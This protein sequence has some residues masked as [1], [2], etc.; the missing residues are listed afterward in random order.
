MN[1]NNKLMINGIN[2]KLDFRRYCATKCLIYIAICKLCNDPNSLSNFYFGQTRNSLMSRNNGHRDKFSIMKYDK[3]A[4]SMHIYDKHLEHFENKLLNYDF[5]VV[6]HVN[7][8]ALDRAEDFY[9][10]VTEA[11]LKGLNRYKLSK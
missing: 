10:F 2:I 11:D 7:P 9:I 4:L 6:K 5:G 1:L 3:S 8:T